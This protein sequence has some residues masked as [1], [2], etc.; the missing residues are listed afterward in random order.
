VTH[1]VVLAP[2]WLG[3]A[4][5]ALPAIAD[6]HRASPE[7]TITVAARPSIAPLFKLVPH[8]GRVLALESS[9]RGESLALR[10]SGGEAALIL[11]NSFHAALIVSRAGIPGRWG[12]RTQWRGFLL[13]RAVEPARAGLHQIEYYQ[14]LVRALGYPNDSTEPR[15]EGPGALREAGA[16]ALATAGWEEDAPLVAL[17]PGAAYGGAKRWPPERFAELIQALAS[18]GIMTVLVGSA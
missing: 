18:D 12:Y 10:D 13:T 7:T 6:V 11:P 15:L 9:G 5:M 3:D 8:V 16:A 2:N 17:S 14:R 1:L 4:V